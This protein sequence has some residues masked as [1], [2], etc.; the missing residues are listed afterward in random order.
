[1]NN[2][3]LT[4]QCKD[5]RGIVATIANFILE[6]NGNIISMDEYTSESDFF[7][8]VEFCFESS[9]DKV[10]EDF[11]GIGWDLKAQWKI[12]DK[13]EKLK[14][15]IL[16]S[17]TDHC[18]EELLYRWSSGELDVDI[19]FVASNHDTHREIIERYK[20]PFHFVGKNDEVKILGHA[21]ET[22]FLVLARYM[23]VL[24]GDFLCKYSKDIINIHHSF[25]PS[26]KGADPYS[27]AHDRGVKIIGSTAHFVTE[28]LDEG[29]IIEQE[30][31]K[32]SHRDSVIDMKK[33]GKLLEKITLARAVQLYVEYRI[34]RQ[35][36]K[37]VV[38]K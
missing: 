37:T 14:V 11:G 31:E 23:Q 9:F 30:I 24:S 8:R 3:I 26:F 16:V 6:H 36:N 25:L 32:V 20:I 28:E 18:L 7:V 29:P 12:Y 10:K 17:K 5:K 27:Q 15:G 1:M 21:K 22:D 19:A 35:K 2:A 13:A 38:F 34:I 33:K 4:L